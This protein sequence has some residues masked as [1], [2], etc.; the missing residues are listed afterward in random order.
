MNNNGG[1]IFSY[2]SQATVEDYYEELFGTPSDLQ[3]SDLAR[4]YDAQ[5]DVIHSKEELVQVLESPKVK[6]VRIIEVVTNRSV[7]VQSH[8]N[9]WDSISKELD[10]KWQA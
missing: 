4:M 2:L 6:P 7:N 1:G 3:F 9:L 8:R 5:Y 10:E